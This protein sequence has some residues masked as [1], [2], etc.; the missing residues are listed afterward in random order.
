MNFRIVIAG[1]LDDALANG[2][3]EIQ[4]AK[5]RIALFEAGDDAQRM[6][7]VIETEAMGLERDVQRFFAGVPKRRMAN[8]MDQREGPPRAAR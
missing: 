3:S 5:C 8:V 6:Q 4:P 7:V 2:E 1:V